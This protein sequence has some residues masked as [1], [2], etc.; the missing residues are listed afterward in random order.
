MGPQFRVEVIVFTVDHGYCVFTVKVRVRGSKIRKRG[1]KVRGRGRGGWID[2]GL[3][4]GVMR[5][6]RVMRVR[7]R[8]QSLGQE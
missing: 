8:M 1:I 7:V 6:V 2:L 3:A 5:V 4:E